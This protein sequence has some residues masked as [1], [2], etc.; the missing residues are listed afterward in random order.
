MNQNWIPV[1]YL[2]A[3]I[4]FI[5]ALKLMKSPVSARHGN[6][7]AA[8]GMFVAIALT[9]F[10]EGIARENFGWI[11]G[12]I[13]VGAAL[14]ILPSRSV[15]MT[16]MPQMVALLNGLGG[17]AVA[18]VSLVEFIRQSSIGADW[19][20]VPLVTTVLSAVIGCVS[21]AG[22][23]IA[24]GKLQEVLPSRAIV[25]PGQKAVNLVLLAS[26]AALAVLIVAGKPLVVLFAALVV[27]SLIV[28][29]SIVIPIGGA[30]MPV[31]ISLLNSF[32]GTAAGLAGFVLANTALLI[33]GGLV[34]ASGL[35]LTIE[36]CRAMNRSLE[37]V[38]FGAF[39]AQSAAAG[40]SAEGKS[41][42]SYSVEDAAIIFSNADSVIIVPGYGMAVA[43]AQHVLK[44]LMTKL[45]AR[46]IDVKFAI[47]PVAGRMPGHM[48]VLLAEADVPYELLYDLDDINTMFPETDV[49]LVVGANDVVNPAARSDPSSQIYG[50]PILDVDKAK[51]C[52]VIKRS[53]NTGFAGIENE[54]F[55]LPN[56]VMVFGD[57]KGV[58]AKLNT[59]IDSY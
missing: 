20:I 40:S 22:S 56:T 5:L 11:I 35:I 51:T 13:L 55:Y 17:G 21:F 26:V 45:Q 18:L 3:A 1:G 52:I 6:W 19:P 44:E 8:G 57:A 15:P 31:V 43:Q 9:F 46:G 49:A 34:G 37:N 59:A 36:M 39:G 38:I 33:G 14:S 50:M 58:I 23:L 25:F 53:M 42:R 24:F 16:G 54:L 41:V 27:V 47:H 7:L 48:N 32:T 10:D 28:G 29:V 2:L 30:D 12:A 4:S